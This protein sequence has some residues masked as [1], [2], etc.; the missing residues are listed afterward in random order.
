MP[1]SKSTGSFPE[2]IEILQQALESERGLK[3]TFPTPE[4]A[5]SFRMRCYSARRCAQRESKKLFVPDHPMHGKSFYDSLVMVISGNILYIKK[6]DSIDFAV[7][8]L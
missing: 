4:A 5:F 1:Q 7:E 6:G 2:C 3:L 8:M